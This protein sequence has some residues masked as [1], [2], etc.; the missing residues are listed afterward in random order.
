M[1][2][3]RVAITGVGGGPALFEMLGLFG[4]EDSLKRLD[5]ALA[6]FEKHS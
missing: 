2:L 3:F 4:K 1:Q 6:H 5:A